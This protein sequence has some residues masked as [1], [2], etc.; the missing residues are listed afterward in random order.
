MCHKTNPTCN[1][2]EG[3]FTQRWK[4]KCKNNR[5]DEWMRFKKNHLHLT[6]A[7]QFHLNWVAVTFCQW[8]PAPQAEGA[9]PSTL[10]FMSEQAH[11]SQREGKTW[12]GGATFS[13]VGVRGGGSFS[14]EHDKVTNKSL[15]SPAPR[16]WT[17]IS[18]KHAEESSRG[19][20]SQSIRRLR[21]AHI[22]LYLV[23]KLD[24]RLQTRTCSP[25]LQDA[26][27]P[28]GTSL[29]SPSWRKTW[30][31]T[32]QKKPFT[33]QRMLFFR[34]FRLRLKKTRKYSFNKVTN[35]YFIAVCCQIFS[36]FPVFR[37]VTYLKFI[38]KNK[39][40]L[41]K[42]TPRVSKDT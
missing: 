10:C 35:W 41:Y 28:R 32:C 33:N 24:H 34:V 9:W 26:E 42:Y 25:P 36:G 8:N 12:G 13:Y 29:S 40:G 27:A 14:S 5:W 37:N 22:S 2:S 11:K 23:I 38:L 31:I 18:K 30:N 15:W 7:E 4:W 39:R 20:N 21:H 17:C 3:K 16:L 19:P 6:I 1:T